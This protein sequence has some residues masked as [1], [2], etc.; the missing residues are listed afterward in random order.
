MDFNAL[1]QQVVASQSPDLHLQVGQHPIIRQKNGEIAALTN[2]P[3]ISDDDVSKVISEITNEEQKKRF[4]EQLE[5]DFSYHVGDSGRFRVNVYQERLGPAI[6]F[7]LISQIIP[8]L[9]D[10]SLTGSAID[11]LLS[12]PNGLVLVT[13]PTGMGKSTTLA[14]MV[15]HINANRR[16][17]IITI[18]DPIE[19]VY[20]NKNCMVTQ[21]EVN[22]HTHSFEKAI[23]SAL[24]QDPD[25]VMVGEMRDLETIAAAI[26]L[27]ETGHLVFSTLHTTDAAQTVDRI[28]DVFP[29]YQQQQIRSQ[30]GNTLRGVVSQVLLPRADGEGR[31]AAREIMLSNDGIR[32]C[33]SRAEVHQIYSMI[34]IGAKEGMILMDQ[35]LENLVT[36]GFITKE[37]AL[38]KAT[39]IET[40]SARLAQL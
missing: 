33:I 2:H 39:D 13:G 15:D 19:Y 22:V 8:S 28:I 26:T 25:V 40:L 29:S 23:R 17:H 32:N 36:Q 24:R 6:A 9:E 3:V 16:A 35:A 10:L 1:I 7:R 14:S 30:L 11:Q 20:Q 12:L 5:F 4:A 34:Q 38:S 21:R 18:E 31:I 27:A 37:D